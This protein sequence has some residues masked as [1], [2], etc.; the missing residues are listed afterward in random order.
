MKAS[1]SALFLVTFTAAVP[2]GNLKTLAKVVVRAESGDARATIFIGRFDRRKHRVSLR[3]LRPG[4]ALRVHVDGRF[5][6]GTEGTDH[7]EYP[8]R[9]IRSI[10]IQAGK[11]RLDLPK[12]M[13]ADTFE[14]PPSDREG[15]H[16]RYWL[17][18]SE[19]KRLARLKMWASDGTA[20]YGV[21]WTVPFKGSCRRTFLYPP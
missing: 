2:Q 11:H 15:D 8:E 9:T 3:R 10:R 5:A 14:P 4:L 16:K 18:V 20:G 13:F 6:W 7:I 21:V 1:F 12:E 17:W 19:R